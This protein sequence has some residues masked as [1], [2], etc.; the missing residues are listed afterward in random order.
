MTYRALLERAGTLP[1][2]ETAALRAW[3][4]DPRALSVQLSRWVQAGKLVQLRR[5]AYLLP[6]ALR[7]ALPAAEYLANLM[8]VPSYVSL[9]RA[10]SIHGVIP[11][12]VPLVQ[13]VTPGRPLAL[14]TPEGDFEYR[15]VKQSWFFGYQRTELGLVALP[16]K[17]LLD[18]VH[19]SRGSFEPERIEALRLQ[20]LERLD[21][22]KLTR[23]ASGHGERLEQA[24]AALARWIRNER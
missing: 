6:K 10:L 3:G 11:E 2:I 14:R 9:E 8:V 23:F 12:R 17:A 24:A 15:H 13:S 4:G 20:E 22:R 16:E 5:G 18:W 7:R 1:V 19:L 21:V